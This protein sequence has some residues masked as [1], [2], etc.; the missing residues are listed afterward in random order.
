MTRYDIVVSH[1][2]R[3]LLETKTPRP[4]M[5]HYTLTDY[6]RDFSTVRACLEFLKCQRWPEGIPC[7]KC[8]RATRHHFIVSRKAFSCQHCGSQTSP[9]KG[10]IFSR[11]NVPLPDWFYV[12]FQFAATRTGITSKQIERELGVSYPTA[13]RMCNLVR[14]AMAEGTIEKLTGEVE[15][16]ETYMGNSR[17]Y[18]GRKRKRG[19]GTDKPPVFGMVERGGRIVAMTVPNCKRKTVFPII[20]EHVEEGTEIHSDEFPVYNTL[21]KEGYSHVSVKHKERQYVQYREGRSPIH[22]NTLEGFWSYP[23]NATKGVHRGVSAHKL[24]GYLNEYTFRRSHR[25]DEQPMF[26]TLM[27]QI[28]QV[29]SSSCPAL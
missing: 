14:E 6:L 15:V 23:K 1:L 3:K 16:D 9:T 7:R 11:S 25:N 5:T 27:D 10:T 21:G 13:L 17:R 28:L 19:R 22:T 24:Q 4:A 18:Y 8:G 20:K 29:P 26:L 12:V 2:V